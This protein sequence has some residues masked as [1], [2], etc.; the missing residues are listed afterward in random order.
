MGVKRAGSAAFFLNDDVSVDGFS[1]DG[2]GIARYKGKTLFVD[3]ALPGETVRVQVLEDKRRFMNARATQ[4]LASSS[5]RCTPACRYFDRCGGCSLQYW[6]HD[7]QLAG[8]EQ[9][10]LDQLRRF[11]G[12]TPL[13]VAKPLMSPSYGYRYR[14]R[15]ALRW[16]KG[17]LQFGLRQKASNAICEIDDCPVLAESLREIP[18]LLPA[19]LLTLT[20]R[21]AISHAECFLADNGR[22]VLLRHLRPLGND[23]RQRLLDFAVNHKL[24]LYLQ[25]SPEHIER[26]SADANEMHYGLGD[27]KL[28]FRPQDFTQVNWLINQA[29]VEQ[30]MDWLTPKPTDRMLDLFCGLGN[31]SLPMARRCHHVTGV[32]G[33]RSSVDQASKNAAVNGLDNV[34]FHCANLAGDFAGQPWAQERYDMLLLDPPRAGA[35]F[36]ITRLAGLLPQRLLYISCNPATLARDTQALAA[37]GYKLL[38][39]GVMDMFPQTAHVESMA[40]FTR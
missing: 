15:F 29:M 5:E 33:S 31:F 36:M 17:Q 35:D 21:E 39:L 20:A 32:E 2:R 34:S 30:A 11:A 7:G 27:L 26:L 24:F 6:S 4:V 16:H 23:D 8:K 40:L 25:G 22:G 14:C 28:Y 18:R 10:V 9:I 19:L 3:G 37:Q 1:H 13:E 38:R 12:V